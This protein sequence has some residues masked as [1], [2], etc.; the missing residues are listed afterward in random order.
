[1]FNGILWFSEHQALP[2]LP[3]NA[4]QNG[5]GKDQDVVAAL[6]ILGQI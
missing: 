2:S 1:M 5:V 6:L 3:W 4:L